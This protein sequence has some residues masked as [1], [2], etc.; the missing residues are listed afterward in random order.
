VP[1]HTDWEGLRR[2]L[3]IDELDQQFNRQ[4]AEQATANQALAQATLAQQQQLQQ[5]QAYHA[6]HM[7]D[8]LRAAGMAD[9]LAYDEVL[10]NAYGLLGDPGQILRY[11]A[12]A[13][14]APA[15]DPAVLER[16]LSLLE[17]KIGRDAVAKIQ[18][19]GAYTIPS[20]LWDGVIYHVPKEPHARVRV[21]DRGSV[22]TE[23]C[24]VT[25]DP[26]IPWPDV[27]LQRITAIRLD[28]S[29]LFA[30]GVIHDRR[31]TS[32]MARAR[33]RLQQAFA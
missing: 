29:V 28:E 1:T 12:G 10:R 24:I 21:V 4:L 18:N 19:G 5:L 16:A 2:A 3:G 6:A 7:Q 27:M 9:T 32:W 17:S 30:T 31:P 13:P 25:T 23:V 11:P 33:A 20:Q 15:P 22:V 14:P 26:S 8:R